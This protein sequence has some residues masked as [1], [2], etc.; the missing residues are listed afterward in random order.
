VRDFLVDSMKPGPLSS[1]S[2]SFLPVS[3]ILPVFDNY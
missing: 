2:F 1:E 3:I